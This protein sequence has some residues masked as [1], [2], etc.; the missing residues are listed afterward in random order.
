MEVNQ[1]IQFFGTKNRGVAVR[2]N[3]KVKAFT[4]PLVTAF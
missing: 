2:N 1:E 4:S 3:Q